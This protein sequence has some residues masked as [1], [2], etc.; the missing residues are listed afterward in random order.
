MIKFSNFNKFRQIPKADIELS[1]ASAM[2]YRNY[3]HQYLIGHVDEK[4]WKPSDTFMA[5]ILELKQNE[6]KPESPTN[7]NAAGEDDRQKKKQK[8]QENH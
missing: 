5:N 8:I 1:M 3:L 2:E 7:N 6:E 4:Y